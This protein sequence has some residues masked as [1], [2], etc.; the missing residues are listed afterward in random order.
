MNEPQRVFYQEIDGTPIVILVWTDSQH[1]ERAKMAL[2]EIGEGNVFTK[3]GVETMEE[4][5]VDGSWAL[6][7]QGP[8]LLETSRGTREFQILVAGH[9]L[10]WSDGALTFRLETGLTLEEARRVAESLVPWNP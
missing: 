6:W 5:T 1:S 2:Y 10:L 9:T 8:H 7:L 4:T 3:R